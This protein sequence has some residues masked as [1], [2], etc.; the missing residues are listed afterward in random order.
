MG[1]N[2]KVPRRPRLSTVREVCQ[3]YLDRVVADKPGNGWHNT[4][5][6]V[7]LFM[8]AKGD[9]LLDDLICDDLESWIEQHADWKSPWTKKRIAQAV[10]RAF[11]W[12]W[13]KGLTNCHPL[14]GVSYPSGQ[15]GEAMSESTFRIYL[16]ESGPEMRR[17][18]FFLWWTGCRPSELCKLQWNHIDP[19]RG[20][21]TL[22]EHKTANTRRDRAPRTIVLPDKALRL[23][24]W[25]LRQLDEDCEPT[26]T[27]RSKR[28]ANAIREGELKPWERIERDGKYWIAESR[29]ALRIGC[30]H[31]LL[32]EWQKNG[33]PWLPGRKKP[34]I[35]RAGEDADG[36]GCRTYCPEIEVDVIAAR[37]RIKK[38]E[39]GDFVFVNAWKGRWRRTNFSTYIRRIR[40]RVGL[41]GGSS[42]HVYGLR[43]AYGT[44]LALAG[45]ELKTLSTLMGHTNS[46][47][48]ERYIHI[49]GK[50]DHLREA[51]EK[52]IG[53][54][55]EKDAKQ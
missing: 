33:C 7:R 41:P 28:R 6:A 27:T 8:D 3:A 45:V 55:K 32:K 11:N 52:G 30:S 35:W 2:G 49:A 12:C 34:L 19:E 50:I 36:L 21:A 20:V 39:G 37:F 4:R 44:R 18:L 26:N 9:I 43:H 17:C 13:C 53:H 38:G 25:I 51:L 40:K 46:L 42:M 23:L 29:A 54:Q 14:K 16:R 48:S 22:K 1:E 5:T 31:R 24:T 15:N 47:M 10:K